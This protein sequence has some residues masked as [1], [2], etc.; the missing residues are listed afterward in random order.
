MTDAG[1]VAAFLVFAGDR[2]QIE[3]VR[4]ASERLAPTLSAPVEFGSTLDDPPGIDPGCRSSLATGHDLAWWRVQALDAAIISSARRLAE[5]TA[6]QLSLRWGRVSRKLVLPPILELRGRA[7][8][9]TTW[10]TTV[11]RL[12][13]LLMTILAVSALHSGSLKTPMATALALVASAA[14]VVA[15]V[16]TLA[17]RRIADTAGGL[18]GGA[19]CACYLIGSVGGWDEPAGRILLGVFSAFALVL[20]LVQRMIASRHPA[21]RRVD[22]VLLAPPRLARAFFSRI[23]ARMQKDQCLACGAPSSGALSC[24]CPRCGHA[25][26][27]RVECPDAVELAVRHGAILRTAGETP[28]V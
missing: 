4:A 15:C 5:R 13:V 19:G 16:A 28:P 26:Y 10:S 7:S 9:G 17:V 2:S 25:N 3:A 22:I 11:I 12:I 21:S 14:L 24:R 27:H 8:G 23:T 1:A 18:V 6:C 20:V